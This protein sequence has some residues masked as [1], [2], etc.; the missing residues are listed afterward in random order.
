M[1]TTPPYAELLAL[2]DDRSAALR[3]AV[4]SA[5]GLDT[6]VPGCPRWSLRDLVTHLGEV[7]R[8]WAAAVT[9]GSTDAPPA[10]PPEPG[11]MPD[12]ELLSFSAASTQVLLTALRAATPEQPCWT[13]WG[14]SAAPMDVGAVA[15]H[16]VQEAAVHAYDAQEAAGKPG[17]VP[18]V[19][20]V[21]GVAEFLTVSPGTSGPWPHRPAV[22]CLHATEGPSWSLSLT[23]SGAAMSHGV[24]DGAV[25]T[26]RG[27]VSD[28]LLLLHGRIGPDRLGVDGDHTV[29]DQLLAWPELT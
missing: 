22:V 3:E 17:P 4:A 24:Q 21:D 28:L 1:S 2:I 6:G 10:G 9:A 26:V 27:P 23:P 20:A 12:A 5:P 29:V 8:F 16:Q 19:V 14:A 11:A 25:A 13:W 7:Q 18:G 15:R